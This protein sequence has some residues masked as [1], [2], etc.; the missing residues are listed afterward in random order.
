MRRQVVKA[1]TVMGRSVMLA[2]PS[3]P[4]TEVDV[5]YSQSSL[6]VNSL[7]ACM[8]ISREAERRWPVPFEPSVLGRLA[9]C[10]FVLDFDRLDTSARHLNEV[11]EA[12]LFW[13]QIWSVFGLMSEPSCLAKISLVGPSGLLAFSHVTTHSINLTYGFVS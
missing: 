12:Y 10:S 8:S 7:N 11:R 3:V 2:V 5:V 6:L 4:L 9:A 13:N 1:K